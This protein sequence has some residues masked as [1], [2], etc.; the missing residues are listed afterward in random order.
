MCVTN[1]SHLTTHY[2]LN[3]TF[4][5]T[6]LGK[7][8]ENTKQKTRERVLCVFSEFISLLF[9]L[10]VQPYSFVLFFVV[11]VIVVAAVPKPMHFTLTIS[12]LLCTTK[13]LSASRVCRP[14]AYLHTKSGSSVDDTDSDANERDGFNAIAR[15]EHN[16]ALTRCSWIVSPHDARIYL[17]ASCMNHLKS[18]PWRSR[19]YCTLQPTKKLEFFIV[20]L[21]T[22]VGFP[23]GRR[24][25]KSSNLPLTTDQNSEEE[26]KFGRLTETKKTHKFPYY[27]VDFPASQQCMHG[28]HAIHEE[29]NSRSINLACDV[30]EPFFS[31]SSFSYLLVKHLGFFFIIKCCVRGANVPHFVFHYTIFSLSHP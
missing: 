9:R 29:W 21:Y 2:E 30:N 27:L 18:E 19:N 23:M 17:N 8:M 3:H 14:R 6:A 7:Q 24:E 31:C 1:I 20:I 11:V 28:V 22:Y 10:C 25:R 26:I 16:G 15:H 12:H 4:Q 5:R 13:H